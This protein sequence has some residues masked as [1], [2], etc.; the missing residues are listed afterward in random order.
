MANSNAMRKQTQNE[1]LMP[2][3]WDEETYIDLNMSPICVL[4]G[5]V[6]AFYPLIVDELCCKTALSHASYDYQDT[7]RSALICRRYMMRALW[8]AEGANG[9]PGPYQGIHPYNPHSC[10]VLCLPAPNTTILSSRLGT[11][12]Q[13]LQITTQNSHQLK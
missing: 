3:E 9:L 13:R 10:L 2:S 6:I 1:A 12:S 5:G 7:V 4:Y 11:A 8:R